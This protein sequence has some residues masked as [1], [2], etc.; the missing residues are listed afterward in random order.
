MGLATSVPTNADRAREA[1][2]PHLWP[3]L[4]S[5]GKDVGNK[6]LTSD[7]ERFGQVIHAHLGAVIIIMM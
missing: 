2:R 6:E 1:R 3:L 7:N 4:M 5:P